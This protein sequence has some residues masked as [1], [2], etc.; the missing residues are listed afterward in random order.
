MLE[1]R[2]ILETESDK[3]KTLSDIVI[4][5]LERKEF[6]IP[7]SEQ[8]YLDMFDN[9]KI[10][11]YGAFDGDKLVGTAQLFIADNYVKT[12]KK[13]LD[14]YDSKIVDL[15]GYLVL[16][17]Y[18]NQGIIKQLQSILFDLAKEM[19]FD[20]IA[21]TAHPE[22]VRSNAAIKNLNPELKKVFTISNG[23]ERNLYLIDLKNNK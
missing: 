5:N 8:V 13:T 20:Y 4:N 23:Y 2:R 10:I 12:I 16:P 9:D 14:I 7:F 22:N 6:F 17:E 19:D 11:A 15:G 18:G 3:I 1:F 21:I